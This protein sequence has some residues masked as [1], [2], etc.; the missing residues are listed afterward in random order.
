[1][2]FKKDKTSQY[3][4]LI[5]GLGNPGD[6]YRSTRHNA[7]FM[8][9]DKMIEKFGARP[10]KT[11]AKG[12]LY[13]IKIGKYRCLLLK[14]TTFMN[15]S[16]EAVSAVMHY[17][18]MPVE[19]LIVIFDDVSLDVGKIRLRRN[20]SAGGH[21]GIKSIIACIGSQ[22]FKRIKI[23]VGKKPHPDYDLVNWVLGKFPKEQI[24]DLFSAMDNAVN[25]AESI[26]SEDIDKAM[27][28]YSS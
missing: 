4:Y 11:R 1:M 13:E 17:Y 25:A 27:N 9:A 7:G 20:G 8:V 16:G 18:K 23:G 19:S 6:K 2:F 28:K 3:D 21:N 10:V 12:D 15:N 26:I 5:T 22:E 24:P 14:P